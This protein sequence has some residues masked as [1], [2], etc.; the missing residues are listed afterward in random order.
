MQ[1][2]VTASVRQ[3]FDADDTTA[4]VDLDYGTDGAGSEL[5]TLTLDQ[6][7]T[8]DGDITSGFYTYGENGE[9][10]DPI[11]LV[12]EGGVIYGVLLGDET[13][14]A[15]FT[16]SIIGDQATAD[17]ANALSGAQEGEANYVEV[18]DM[19]F[20]QLANV[21]HPDD[22]KYDEGGPTVDDARLLVGNA[23]LN[24]NQTLTDADGDSSTVTVSYTHLTLP[25]ILRV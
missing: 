9:K 13:S 12:E 16:I 11:Y 14:D 19:T 22:A 25:T 4:D 5:Y 8:Q 17:A 15:F 24:V 1:T 3:L 10:G 18:G 23:T 7:E 20:T 2:S 21:W 6:D